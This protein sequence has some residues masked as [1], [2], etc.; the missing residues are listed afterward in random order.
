MTRSKRNVWESNS[1]RD[2]ENIL[3]VTSR[4]VDAAF[5]VPK[6][7]AV[8]GHNVSHVL[9]NL[10][11]QDARESFEKGKRT[12]MDNLRIGTVWNASTKQSDAK[13]TTWM[14][15][16]LK[17]TP[18]DGVVVDTEEARHAFHEVAHRATINHRPILLL[19]HGYNN[20]VTSPL[21]AASILREKHDC[22]VIVFMWPTEGRL[23][24][25]DDDL[26]D[27]RIT[28][29]P[30]LRFL[31]KASAFLDIR[32]RPKI[33]LMCHSMGNYVLQRAV[34]FTPVADNYG[35]IDQYLKEGRDVLCS[36][37]S[38]LN[39]IVLTAADVDSHDHV[40]WLSQLR[41]SEKVFI[42]INR[43]DKLLIMSDMVVG[44]LFN[45]RDPMSRIFV[46][47]KDHPPR[48]GQTLTDINS[49]DGHRVYVDVNV[50]WKGALDLGQ[51]L[52]LEHAYHF[53]GLGEIAAFYKDAIHGTWDA[54]KPYQE[55]VQNSKGCYYYSVVGP[56]SEGSLFS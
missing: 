37:P 28:A 1:S 23:L 4:S 29:R 35:K 8:L 34:A 53:D 15:N 55:T 7:T 17:D 48:L 10:L 49:N 40:T 18:G 33:T 41:P 26:E 44:K 43:G 5:D 36:T 56:S 51:L 31:R 14:C 54:K 38:F 16:I 9:T 32:H 52:E 22:E 6:G 11:T 19:V 27:T 39:N 13:S 2:G 42:C 45:S 24:H 3:F 20:T 12:E 47:G 50:T 21:Q 46:L 30:F 25:Y